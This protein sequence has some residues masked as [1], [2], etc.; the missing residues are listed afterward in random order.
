MDKQAVFQHYYLNRICFPHGMNLLRSNM[1]NNFH[2][3][4]GSNALCQYE[5]MKHLRVL[6]AVATMFLFD[7]VSSLPKLV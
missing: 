5:Y 2:H 3:R 7:P 6:Q 1:Q 4:Q